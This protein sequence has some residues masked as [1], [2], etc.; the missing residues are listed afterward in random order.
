[1]TDLIDGTRGE[2]TRLVGPVDRLWVAGAHADRVAVEEREEVAAYFRSLSAQEGLLVVHTCH[3]VEVVGSTV[4]P[5]LILAGAPAAGAMRRSQGSDAVRHILRLATGLESAVVGE[6]QI[7][8]Q[9]RVAF[10]GAAHSLPPELRRLGEMA[11]AAGREARAGQVSRGR[12]LSRP[13][14]QWLVDRGVALDG[15]RIMIVGAGTLGMRLADVAHSRGARVLV[16]SRDSGRARAVARR[17]GG[18]AID[19]AQAAAAAPRMD[20]IAVALGGPWLDLRV[21]DD[22]PPM[23]DLSAPPAVA[24]EVR[25]RM[26]SRFGDVDQL[27]PARVVGATSANG[28]AARAD[29]SSAIAGPGSATYI[30]RAEGVVGAWAARYE[31]WLCGR[32]AVPTLCSLRDRSEAR[33]RVAVERLLR[34]LPDLGD[35]D[36][37]LI[38]AFSEQ[39]TAALL[40]EPSARLRE[41]EDGSAALAARAL[42][43]LPR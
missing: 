10:T 2:V 8:G 35:R 37:Q 21:D 5:S 40:H 43:D 38:S 20:G 26:G 24:F 11:L 34:R 27:Y 9:I 6:D 33:R 30:E 36:Q 19:L 17:H 16:A 29:T 42:F 15:G 28:P 39:L 18:V 23:V 4:D 32:S 7:L 14:L 12:D 1:M 41:D 22:L 25:A 3:R 13:A 31:R